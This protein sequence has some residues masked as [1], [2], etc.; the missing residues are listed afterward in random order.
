MRESSAKPIKPIEI[1]LV[2]APAIGWALPV[3]SAVIRLS[4]VPMWSA[5]L[6]ALG[7]DIRIAILTVCGGAGLVALPF[8]VLHI[9]GSAEQSTHRREAMAMVERILDAT[10]TEKIRIIREQA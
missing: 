9:I 8:I 4:T 6:I 7:V 5:V 10:E 3:V 2:Q 1:R